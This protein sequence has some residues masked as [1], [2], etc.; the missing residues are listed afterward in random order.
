MINWR[1]VF[2]N[3]IWIAGAATVLAVFGHADW[4]ASTEGKGLRAAVKSVSQSPGF[5]L[6]MALHARPAS[7]LQSFNQ[8]GRLAGPLAL[9]Y[10]FY[11]GIMGLMTGSALSCF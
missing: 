5:V 4:R 3:L 2:R 7:Y 9:Q 10:P 8:A 6:G 11:G 1:Q